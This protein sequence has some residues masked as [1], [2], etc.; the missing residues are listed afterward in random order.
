MT[1]KRRKHKLATAA[2]P[3]LN[4]PNKIFDRERRE[5]HVGDGFVVDYEVNQE[6]D[7]RA[8]MNESP[9]T[10]PPSGPREYYLVRYA[11]VTDEGDNVRG[12][13]HHERIASPAV[14]DKLVAE[15]ARHPMNTKITTYRVTET[16]EMVGLE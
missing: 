3:A 8:P 16:W 5:S 4:K 7:G 15:L 14:V 9:F 2:P 6:R 11:E 10:A 1:L 12:G 13:M